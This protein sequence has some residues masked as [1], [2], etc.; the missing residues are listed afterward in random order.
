MKE[1][2]GCRMQDIGREAFQLRMW[3]GKEV[4]IGLIATVMF[5]NTALPASQLEGEEARKGARS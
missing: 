5:H 4:L 2:Q 3:E 1:A